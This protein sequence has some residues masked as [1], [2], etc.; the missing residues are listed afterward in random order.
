MFVSW[1]ENLVW[2]ISPASTKICV[3]A[4]WQICEKTMW[5]AWTTCKQKEIYQSPTCIYTSDR[6]HGDLSIAGM[7]IHIRQ[8]A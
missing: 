8:T 1:T 2:M 7:Y 6:Q 5:L 3:S 4:K